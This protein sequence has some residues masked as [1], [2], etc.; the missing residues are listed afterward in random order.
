MV[1][2][3]KEQRFTDLNGLSVGTDVYNVNTLKPIDFDEI[4]DYSEEVAKNF[5]NFT[6][7]NEKNKPR[8]KIDEE[9]RVIYKTSKGDIRCADITDFAFTQ[10]CTHLNL[11]ASYVKK[12]FENGKEELALANFR[13]WSND[14]EKNLVFKEYQGVIRGV[15][16]ESY[17]SFSNRRMCETLR[18]SVDFDRYMPIQAN[19][20]PERIT[21]RF[22]ERES[23]LIDGDKSPIWNG[24][25]IQN[26]DVG[27]GSLQ[28]NDFMYRQWCTNGCVTRLFDGVAFKQSHRGE[29]AGEGK[30]VIFS[31]L[32]QALYDLREAKVKLMNK[33]AEKKLEFE[34]YKNFMERVS[35]NLRLS[36]KAESNLTDII[37]RYYAN[38]GENLTEW[39]VINGITQFAQG[40]T[41]DKRLE[42]ESYAGKLLTASSRGR[43]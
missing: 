10:L 34:E 7:I 19:L 20:Q 25:M 6:V 8:F 17:K 40:Y 41:L 15:V 22:V 11:P 37:M 43:R 38:N 39:N 23:T 31:Q 12:C 2:K 27:G 26:N 14:L 29:L 30:I 4:C 9:F 5:K 1:V 13:A 32:F 24:F 42:L 35:A 36:E 33:S 18:N 21:V 28:I 16:T 3:E